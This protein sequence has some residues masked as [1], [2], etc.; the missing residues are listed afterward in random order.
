MPYGIYCKVKFSYGVVS[1]T[2][3]KGWIQTALNDIIWKPQI[4]NGRFFPWSR[5][6]MIH[7]YIHLKTLSLCSELL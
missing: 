6:L 5:A 4:L 1:D 2:S 7:F 3:S